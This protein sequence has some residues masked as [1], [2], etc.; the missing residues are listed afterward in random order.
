MSYTIMSPVKGYTGNAEFGSG[1]IAFNDGEATVD[2]LHSGVRAYMDKH[3]YTVEEHAAGPFDPTAHSVKEVR[4][5]ID[6]LD[7]SDPEKRDAEILRVV[8]AE[9]AGKARKSV[10]DILDADPAG[11]KD[12]DQSGG[13]DDASGSENDH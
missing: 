12:E 1:P 10:L 3:G 9:Q 4:A 5:H 6:G 8:E 2:D 13:D 11:D 7:D